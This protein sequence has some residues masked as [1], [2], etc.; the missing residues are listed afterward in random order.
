MDTPRDSGGMHVE[1]SGIPGAPAI[2]FLHGVGQSSRE[3][4]EHM[5]R[6][7]D[8]HCLAPDLPGHGRSNHLLLPSNDE[9]VDDLAA[10]IEARVP[11]GRAHVVG[12]SWGAFLV[13]VLMQRHPDRVER[14]VSDGT[15]LVWPRWAKPMVL[16]LTAITMPFLHTRPVLALYRDTHDAADLR[17]ASRRAFWQVWTASLAHLTAAT[18][19][20][21]PTLLVAG[22][23]EG[24]VRPSDAALASLMP[25]AEAWYAPGLDHCWQRVAPD[26]HV[27]MVEAWV[28]GQELPAELMRELAP[29]PE[30]VEL[31]R[32][33][34]PGNWY[35][36]HR[37]RIMLEIRLA[38]RHDRRLLVGTYGKD[39]GEV[40]ARQTMRR[41]E[42]LL[43]EVPYIGGHENPNTQT[44]YMTAYMLALYQ[45]LR[46]HGESV[47]SAA[48][49]L[50]QGASRF[51]G[52]FPLRLLLRWQGRRMFDQAVIEQRRRR[53]IASQERR[54][55]D[56]WVSEFV[57]GD[58]HRIEHG[59]DY[60]E[61]GIVKY[62][63]REGAPELAPYLCWLD[64]PGYAAMGVKLT[65]TQTI[66]QGGQTCDFRFSRGT[67]VQFEPEFL[68]V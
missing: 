36:Q 29:S 23:K 15:P 14:A 13:Q 20:P 41:F 10:L 21:C 52:S 40:I 58:G 44:L 46:M 11:A 1:Q 33:M 37:T 45:S 54:Y 25:H 63:K 62:L 68:H 34:T 38:F 48:R 53:A 5:A 56:D 12:I 39:A 6:L 59:L 57:E 47:E 67:P 26:L 17:M 31:V 2:L 16:A 9:L 32:G 8:F 27:R 55:P 65:R 66:A 18:G 60:R 61:C 22:E 4:R 24:Y 19:S 50:Y 35:L 64:Y 42:A 28:S 51:M 7:S 43:P 3:W 49:L 30:A